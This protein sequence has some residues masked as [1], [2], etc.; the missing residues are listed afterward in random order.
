MEKGKSLI[1]LNY[2]GDTRQPSLTDLLSLTDNSDPLNIT[3]GNPNLK[4]SYNQSVRLEAQNIRKGIFA[5]LNWQNEVNSQTRTITYNRQT[6]GRES[7]PV[8][9]NGNWNIHGTLR[10]QKRIRSFNISAVG[11]G[12]LSKMSVSSMKGKVN[13]RTTV[14]P[15]TPD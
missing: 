12:S 6:G 2:R 3:R 10:Y 4:P 14:L 13:N 8:N 7:Y 5:T 11:G 9:I 1:R 15:I